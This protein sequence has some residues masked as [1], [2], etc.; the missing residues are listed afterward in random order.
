MKAFIPLFFLAFI[1]LVSFAQK[2]TT[3]YGKM[4]GEYYEYTVPFIQ[5]EQLYQKIVNGE[6][7]YLLDT[8]ESKEYEVSAIQGAMHAGFLF[9][10]KKTVEE[11][12]KNALV[13]VYCTIGARSETIG[14]RLLKND[15]TRVYNLYGGIIYWKNQ[16]YPVYHD[17]LETQNVHVYSKKWGQWLVKGK[18]KY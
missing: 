2:D 6:K 1:S 5:P 13:V 11:I 12:D 8:R 9:F 18:A 15:F 3:A 17:G 10:S 14:E 4:L 16:G 7:I